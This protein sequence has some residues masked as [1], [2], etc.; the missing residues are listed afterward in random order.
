MLTEYARN[1][2]GG[3]GAGASSTSRQLPASVVG[4]ALF[5]PPNPGVLQAAKDTAF[6]M[7]D[8]ANRYYELA[9]DPTGLARTHA[10]MI[11]LVRVP[12]NR[13]AI[14]EL[15]TEARLVI[16]EEGSGGDPVPDE[17]PVLVD[18]FDT[19]ILF[20]PPAGVTGLDFGDAFPGWDSASG[21]RLVARDGKAFFMS[22][23]VDGDFTTG[24]DNLYSSDTVAVDA[25]GSEIVN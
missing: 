18:G 20:V 9:Q 2:R 5:T 8:T 16:F 14:D 7:D 1:T 21:P 22:A 6:D 25:A 17:V 11:R 10:I 12:T 13:A 19:P 23:G 24:G 4:N 3:V 15:P